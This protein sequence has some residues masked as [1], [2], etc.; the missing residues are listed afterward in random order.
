MKRAGLA[1]AVLAGCNQILGIG[2]TRPWDA[3]GPIDSPD[4]SSA[5]TWQTLVG[6]SITTDPID[7]LAVQVGSLDA[8]MGGVDAPTSYPLKSVA[9]DAMGNFS[10]PYGVALAPYRVV[11]T[12]PDGL[13]T[14]LQINLQGFHYA[15]PL[16]GPHTRGAVTGGATF[17]GTTTTPA[18]GVE[19]TRLLTTGLWSYTEGGGSDFSFGYQA[20]GV[21]LSGPLGVPSTADGDV[22]VVGFSSEVANGAI[23]D[24]YAVFTANGLGSAGSAALVSVAPITLGWDSSGLSGASS[25]V[26]DSLGGLYGSNPPI[27]APR[28]GGAIPSTSMPSFVQPLVAATSATVAAAPPPAMLP[29]DENSQDQP[30]TFQNPFDGTTAAPKLPLAVYAGD[31]VTRTVPKMAPLTVPAY[32]TTSLQSITLQP[33]TG[34]AAPQDAVGIVT[35]TATAPLTFGGT[36]LGAEYTPVAMGT[37]S[38]LPLAFSADAKVDDCSVVLFRV[39]NGASSASL[40]PLARYVVAATPASSGFPILVDTKYLDTS[41]V[42][43]FGI[44]CER[45]Y[46]LTMN[47]FTQVTYPFSAST[48]FSATFTMQ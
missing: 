28:W 37:A 36:A 39:E 12:A 8:A 33:Q 35:S 16:Y 32:L 20:N 43:T 46:D 4:W 19:S 40:T 41:S 22:E 38:T 27:P 23:D 45:G 6:G 7:G 26:G 24:G 9:V 13:P 29:L 25:R 10:V 44:H 3:H 42:F 11:F 5:I 15:F 21:S 1:L 47:D 34:S 30:F 17:S 2:T 14:E 18:T 48:T 31:F